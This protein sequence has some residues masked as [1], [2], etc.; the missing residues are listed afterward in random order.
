M[1]TA[2]VFKFPNPMYRTCFYRLEALS[3]RLL[4]LERDVDALRAVVS[5][6]QAFDPGPLLRERFLEKVLR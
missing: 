5:I 1:T 3:L 4:R 6:R 2:T